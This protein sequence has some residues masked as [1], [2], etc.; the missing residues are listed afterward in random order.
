MEKKNKFKFS[1]LFNFFDIALIL[2]AVLIALLLLL[3]NILGGE[4]GKKLTVRYTIEVTGFQD[5]KEKLFSVGDSLLDVVK[6]Y[7]VG[8][9]V[10]V[11]LEPT[12]W[13]V[14]DYDANCYVN[15]P[16]PGQVTV[17]LTVESDALETEDAISL[18][19]GFE[20][21]IGQGVSL[22]T[23]ALSFSGTV[24]GIEGGEH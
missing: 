20:I 5:G 6:K 11:K 13:S 8:K 7:E 19:G 12:V 18:D 3:S 24:I 10:E 4:Q 23:P 14:V 2:I 1:H 15:S 17:L 21:R 16:V 22:R 9:I